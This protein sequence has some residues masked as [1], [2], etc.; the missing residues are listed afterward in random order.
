VT[1][2]DRLDNFGQT[3]NIAARI[4]GLAGPGEIVVSDDVLATPGATEVIAGLATEALQV[5][6]RGVAGPVDV[7]RLRR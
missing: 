5:E 7:H 1:L 3:V 4:Q 2:N 6:L